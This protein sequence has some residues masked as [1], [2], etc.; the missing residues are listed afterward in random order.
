MLG[1]AGGL[2]GLLLAWGGL[3]LVRLGPSDYASLARMDW[4]MLG[5][6]LLLAFVAKFLPYGIV[7]SR[8][9]ILQIHPDLEQ[10]ARMTGADGLKALRSITMPLL[11]PTLTLKVTK[12]TVC[13]HERSPRS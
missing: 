1:T 7:V 8:A 6:T 10:S 13:N 2:L 3:W 5:L 12:T 11:K 4:E 9:A